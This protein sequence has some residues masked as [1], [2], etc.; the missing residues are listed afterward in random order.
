MTIL[1]T[2]LDFTYN[3]DKGLRRHCEI[4]IIS[5]RKVGK[6]FTERIM[7]NKVISAYLFPTTTCLSSLYISSA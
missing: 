7:P 6:S 3:T 1:S 2:D 4:I 5:T